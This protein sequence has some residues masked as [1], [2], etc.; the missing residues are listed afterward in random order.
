M[1]II[2]DAM[3][4]DNAPSEIV[5]GAYEAAKEYDVEIVLTGDEALISA[6]REENEIA[7][8]T[9]VTVVHTP[10]AISMEDPPLS[11]V[12]GKDDSSMSVGLR[13]LSEGKGDAFVSAGNTGA[14]HAGSS[15]IVRRIKGIQRSAIATVLPFAKPL[16]L[17]DSGANTEV[18]PTHLLQFGIMGSIYMNKIMGVEAPTVGLLNNGSEPTKGTKKVAQSYEL[19]SQSEN[20]SFAGNIEGKDVPF[21][22]CDVLVTD[23]FTGNIL[24]KSIEG[25]ASFMMGKLKDVFYANLITKLSA[26]P[27]KGGIKNLKKSFDASE[28]GGAPLLGLSKPVIKAHGSSDA[29]ALKN[30]V[31]QAIAFVD[32]GIIVEIVHQTVKPSDE[33]GQSEAAPVKVSETRTEA[34][35]P[36][37]DVE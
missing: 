14:L 2:I 3:G 26:I 5:R 33:A 1:K 19:L 28:Y 29:N 15:L 36:R 6:V 34:E 31:R 8:D 7:E 10:T 30:A 12:R 32:T 9:R 20:I 24:L 21:G 22:K 37:E 13:M 25:F 35:E 23:G 27:I 18:E 4:G 17:I 11:V 16:L